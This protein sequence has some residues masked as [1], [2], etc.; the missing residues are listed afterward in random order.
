MI[1]TAS[2]IPFNNTTS[3]PFLL[4]RASARYRVPV[5][6]QR[7]LKIVTRLSLADRFFFATNA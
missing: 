2:P 3:V 1:K 6:R 4:V 5:K 7:Y